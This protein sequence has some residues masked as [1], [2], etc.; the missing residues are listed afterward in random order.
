MKSVWIVGY[1]LWGVG[2]CGFMFVAHQQNWG[3]DDDASVGRPIGAPRSVRS[4][5]GVFRS[6]YGWGDSYRGGK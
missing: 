2:V 5:P 1:V 6:H 3:G 4:N